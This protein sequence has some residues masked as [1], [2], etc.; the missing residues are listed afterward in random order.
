MLFSVTPRLT[1]SIIPYGKEPR[2][3]SLVSS[4]PLPRAALKP[5][6][7]TQ[8]S[9]CSNQGYPYIGILPADDNESVSNNIVV[10]HGS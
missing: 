3:R 5:E 6:D 10:I 1:F 4:S 9:A 2:E 7:R 8:G